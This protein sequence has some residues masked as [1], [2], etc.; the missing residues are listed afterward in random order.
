MNPKVA[1]IIPTKNKVE[2]LAS[3]L[4]S[5]ALYTEY[6]KSRL[7]I[8]IADTGS[9]EQEKMLMRNIFAQMKTRGFRCEMI[10]FDYYRFGKINNEVVRNYVDED[11]DLLIFMNNDVTLMSD[12]ISNMVNLYLKSKSMCGTIGCLLLRPDGTIQHGGMIFQYHDEK[13][14]WG[15]GH[16]LNK[17]DYK[18]VT[19]R[20]ANVKYVASYGNTAAMLLMSKQ[21]FVD[22]GMFDEDYEVCFEDV[23][24]NIKM[25]AK[26][27]INITDF[28]TICLHNESSTRGCNVSVRDMERVIQFA[29]DN[30]EKIME[31]DDKI[32][33]KE[34]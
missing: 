5:I 26:G 10:E 33:K 25:L 28:T 9:S 20:L 11:T 8:Y 34:K 7:V 1:V 12:A 16:V 32:R 30:K 23:A 6:E 31:F 18:D 17:K 4:M 2:L 19:N 22:V 3:A 21:L 29:N 24:L 14:K 27:L 15:F 13:K